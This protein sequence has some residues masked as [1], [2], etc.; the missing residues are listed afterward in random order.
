MEWVLP[1]PSVQSIENAELYMHRFYRFCVHSWE[2]CT[3]GVPGYRYTAYV[4]AVVHVWF[5]YS[6]DCAGELEGKVQSH[7]LHAFSGQGLK[8]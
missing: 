8:V 5:T 1:Q 3:T 2:S 7:P 6:I 4:H